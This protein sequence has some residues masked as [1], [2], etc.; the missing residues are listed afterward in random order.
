MVEPNGGECGT[1][2]RDLLYRAMQNSS[3]DHLADIEWLVGDEAAAILAKQA[4]GDSPP[5]QR[6]AQLRLKLTPRRAALVVEQLELRRRAGA[7]FSCPE[8]MF[9]TR[10]GLEQATDQLLAR[11]KAGRFAGRQRLADI[12]CG[13]GGDLLALA[14]I[15]PAVAIDLCPATLRLAMANAKAVG[16]TEV[17]SLNCDAIQTPLAEFDA[18]HIDP[19]RRAAGRRSTQIESHSPNLETLDALHTVQPNSA[20]KLAPATEPPSHWTSDRELEWISRAGEC[21]QL[22]V[23]SGE[24]ATGPGERQATSLGK[25]GDIVGQLRGN[26]VPPP[27][28]APDVGQAIYEPDPAMFASD[29]AGLLAQQ[30][31]LERV[32]AQGGY[33]TGRAGKGSPLLAE[34]LVEEVLP[35]RPKRIAEFLASRRIGTVEL[36][37]RGAGADLSQLRKQLKPSGD[38]RATLLLTRREK[39]GV[40]IVAQRADCPS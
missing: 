9:F 19:D 37:Q 2:D 26:P 32:S 15:G 21:K 31:Q 30:Q 33:L 35:L 39:R 11:Y 14:E 7:K 24:L 29:L 4:R 8:R 18:W 16:R 5:H 10:V 12:C 6:L 22:V 38:G 34:F 3:D 40:A 23:W 1:P 28:I 36:K 17:S 25:S 13:V 27:P 20:I